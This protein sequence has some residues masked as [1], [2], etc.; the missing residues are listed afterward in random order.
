MDI[1]NNKEKS[2]GCIIIKDNEVLLVQHNKGHWGFP[3]GHVE[4]NETEMETAVRE[5]K[6]E[7]NVDV[8]IIDDKRYTMEYVT[9]K[10]RDKEVVYFIANPIST[11]IKP[12]E[13]EIKN[14]KWVSFSEALEILSYKNTQDFFENILNERGL[15]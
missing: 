14:I 2:C 4:N 9:D 3:K 5:V 1:V 7:T 8:K 6:E 15:I 11:E 13:E 10:G 12:Q